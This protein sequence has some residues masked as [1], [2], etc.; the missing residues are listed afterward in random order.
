MYSNKQQAHRHSGVPVSLQLH[1]GRN[2]QNRYLMTRLRAALVTPLTGS[3][4]PFGYASVAGLTLWARYAAQLPSPWD[5]VELAVQ[6]TAADPAAAMYEAIA[7]HPDVVFGPYGSSTALAALRVT[8]RVVWDHGGATSQLSRPA[9]PQVINVIS[10]ASTYFAGV[11]EA[12]RVTDPSAATVTI[13]HTDRGFGQ[14][15]AAGA[16]KAARDLGF[17]VR[18]FPFEPNHAA[19]TASTLPIADV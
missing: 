14:D 17:E 16:T 3:L 6:D 13:L 19:G 15:V 5:G 4:A 12:V 11:L 10:P 8:D 18:A 7:T 2:Q 1:V 9:F